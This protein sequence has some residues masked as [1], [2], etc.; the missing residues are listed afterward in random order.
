MEMISGWFGESCQE[1]FFHSFFTRGEC[2]VKAMIF[3][4]DPPEQNCI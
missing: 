2:K 4:S 1:S 3:G